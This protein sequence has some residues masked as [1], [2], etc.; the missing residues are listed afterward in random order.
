M[1]SGI[2]SIIKNFSS[3]VKKINCINSYQYLRSKYLGKKGYINQ[4]IRCL[5]YLEAKRK[6]EIGAKL[7]KTKIKVS[8]E[9][10]KVK[11]TYLF[12]QDIDTR[13]SIDYNLPGRNYK[14]GVKHPISKVIEDMKKI[15]ASMG[16]LHVEGNEIETDWY[17]FTALNIPKHHPARQMHD[18]FYLKKFDML[19]RTHTLNTK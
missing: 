11:N 16:F 13:I 4:V 17:N 15:F 12:C 8:K 6:K 18:T 5:T 1:I 19:L 7:N 2:S 9:L 14:R 10:E 3:E